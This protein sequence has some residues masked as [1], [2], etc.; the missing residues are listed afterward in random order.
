MVEEY[1]PPEKLPFLSRGSFE[2]DRATYKEH[3]IL[4]HANLKDP[5]IRGVHDSGREERMLELDRFFDFHDD[6]TRMAKDGRAFLPETNPEDEVKFM[7]LRYSSIMK[8]FADAYAGL[9]PRVHLEERIDQFGRLLKAG[10]IYSGETMEAKKTLLR[11]A[12]EFLNSKVK[13]SDK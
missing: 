10:D 8:T 1:K 12:I 3:R 9:I 6:Y 2:E 4:L 5:R 11:Y 13:S 7:K